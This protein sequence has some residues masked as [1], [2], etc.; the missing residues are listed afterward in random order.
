MTKINW[1]RGLVA[2]AICTVVFALLVCMLP[3]KGTPADPT[4][5]KKVFEV[6]RV[7]ETLAFAYAAIMLAVFWV[8]ALIR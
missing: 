8:C 1:R 4:G 6:P 2:V 5:M 7:K 3:G